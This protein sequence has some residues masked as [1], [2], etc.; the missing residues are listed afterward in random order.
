[1]DKTTRFSDFFT[2]GRQISA[3]FFPLPHNDPARWRGPSLRTKSVQTTQHAN[4]HMHKTDQCKS[5]LYR[6][7]QQQC[8]R[9]HNISNGFY[10][11][12]YT[13]AASR[14]KSKPNPIFMKPTRLLFHTTSTQPAHRHGRAANA[15]DAKCR[16][17]EISQNILVEKVEI[18]LIPVVKLIHFETV[19]ICAFHAL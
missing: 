1:M 15:A 9:F 10:G 19:E 18:C 17:M 7:N 5:Y 11:F 8:L 6:R 14:H 4:P 12:W 16:R 2:H 13:A 3:A